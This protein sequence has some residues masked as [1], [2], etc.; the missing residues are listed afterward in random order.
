MALSTVPD[1]A[2]PIR[3]RIAVVHGLGALATDFLCHLVMFITGFH[4]QSVP[5]PNLTNLTNLTILTNL[6]PGKRV[7]AG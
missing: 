7:M 5:A 6:T 1:P 2:T 3:K 4:S